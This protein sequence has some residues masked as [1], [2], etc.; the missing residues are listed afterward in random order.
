MSQNLTEEVTY[1]FVKRTEFRRK[2]TNFGDGY[3]QIVIDGINA[4]K[5]TWD[6]EFVALPTTQANNLEI[7]LKD[8]INGTNN[9]LKWL[10]PGEINYKYYVAT[11]ISKVAIRSNK[12]I[13]SC[14]LERE[15]PLTT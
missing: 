8:S 9:Y 1:N 2:E 5:E 6:V 12:F 13:V 11:N 10:A 3:K 14:T 7:K 15:Y 4:D